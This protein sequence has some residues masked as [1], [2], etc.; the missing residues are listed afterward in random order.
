VFGGA[1]T[2]I[3][4]GMIMFGVYK[5]YQISTDVGEIKDLLRDIKS[6]TDHVA[7]PA[8]ASSDAPRP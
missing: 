8:L 4:Y 3:V 7:P 5:L 1:V 6:N 2:L